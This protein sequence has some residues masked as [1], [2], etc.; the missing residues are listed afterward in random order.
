MRILLGLLLL[1]TT[2]VVFAASPQEIYAKIVKANG[3][4]TYPRLVI[5]D[6]DE[7][8]AENRGAV[9]VVHKGLLRTVKNDHELA[10]V[11]GHELAHGKLW[12]LGS[13]HENEYEADRVG[14]K[15]MNKAG[16]NRCRGAKIL[17]KFNKEAS[18]SHPAA[19][20]RYNRVRC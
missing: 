11:L 6:S 7:V 4:W 10:L 2:L 19:K 3:F 8:Q 17:L 20:D 15:Y 9:I 5:I 1:C 18:D 13:T 12:H 16:Y 14:M